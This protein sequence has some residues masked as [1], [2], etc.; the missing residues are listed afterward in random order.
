VSSSNA[1]LRLVFS[2]SVTGAVASP[3]WAAHRQPVVLLCGAD[4]G[5][6]RYVPV[7]D[8][9]SNPLMPTAAGQV[10]TAVNLSGAGGWDIGIGS[11][12][13]D[14]RDV[15]RVEILLQPGAPA[16][17]TPEFS[18]EWAELGF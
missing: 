14:L 8:G 5:Y 2:H 1:E 15:R 4:G 3:A 18:V 6:A 13:L 12:G 9:G 11:T 10:S 16:A 17:G 7:F